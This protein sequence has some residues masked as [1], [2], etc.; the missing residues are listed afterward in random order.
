MGPFLC[1]G[2]MR[3]RVLAHSAVS[4]AGIDVHGSLGPQ[5]HLEVARCDCQLRYV[6]MNSS[7]RMRSAAIH[8]VVSLMAPAPF[9][10]IRLF[11]RLRSEASA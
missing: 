8:S 10:R 2:Q 3:H 5:G 7:A 1:L 6:A 9:S 4:S 11:A